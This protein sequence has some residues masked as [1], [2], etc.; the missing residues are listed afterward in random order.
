MWPRND[1]SQGPGSDMTASRSRKSAGLSGFVSFM[2]RKDA[3]TAI[4]EM[5]G[6]DYGCKGY[7][8]G[9][10]LVVCTTRSVLPVEDTLLQPLV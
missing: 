4:R 7:H 3:E 9:Y 2:K 10:R 6:F 5:D 8:S 1:A